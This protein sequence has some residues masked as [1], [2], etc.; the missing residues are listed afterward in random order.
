MTDANPLKNNTVSGPPPGAGRTF[1]GY[2]EIVEGPSNYC[3]FCGEWHRHIWHPA[4]ERDANLTPPDG[5]G[6]GTSSRGVLPILGLGALIVTVLLYIMTARTA[7]HLDFS[8]RPQDRNSIT[9][10]AA[11][12]LPAGDNT[13]AHEF[14]K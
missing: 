10:E 8:C 7:R 6:A 9:G 5:N 12:R 3:F 14:P 4:A 11:C 1:S 13:S 2:S